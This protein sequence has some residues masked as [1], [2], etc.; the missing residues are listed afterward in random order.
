[1]FHLR[2]FSGGSN[3][4]FR[5]GCCREAARFPAVEIFFGALFLNGRDARFCLFE[6]RSDLACFMHICVKQARVFQRETF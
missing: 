2:T 3:V 6:F 4:S 1:M 5:N